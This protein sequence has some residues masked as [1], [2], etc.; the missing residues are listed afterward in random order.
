MAEKAT[1]AE[2]SLT[3]QGGFAASQS[4]VPA[5]ALQNA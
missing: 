1:T 4:G 3:S 2:A 5:A